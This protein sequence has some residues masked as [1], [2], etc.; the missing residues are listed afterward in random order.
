[1]AKKNQQ[2]ECDECGAI[3][4]IKF[5]ID[6]TTSKVSYCPFCASELSEDDL[7]LAGE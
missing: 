2:H 4:H 6:E 5:E 3:F 1:M 7:Y